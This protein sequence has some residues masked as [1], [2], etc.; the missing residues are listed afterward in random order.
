MS[1]RAAQS[2][3][4]EQQRRSVIAICTK[5]PSHYTRAE[6]QQSK[7]ARTK[8]QMSEQSRTSKAIK[9]HKNNI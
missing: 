1:G 5:E 3:K 2:E 8:E 7:A 6:Q 4:V 9:M